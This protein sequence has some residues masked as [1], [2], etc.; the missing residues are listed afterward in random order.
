MPATVLDDASRLHLNE[1]SPVR[2]GLLAAI[3]PDASVTKHNAEHIRDR[4]PR[5]RPDIVLMN[6]P[7]AARPTIGKRRRH[8]DLKHLKSAYAALAPCGRLIAV[9][10]ANCIPEST[11]WRDAF[12]TGAAAPRILLAVRIP[13]ALY[14]R[15]GTGV[16]TRLVVLERAPAAS[17]DRYPEVDPFAL[18]EDAGDLVRRVAALPERLVLD[19]EPREL[20]IEPVGREGGAPAAYGS[21]TWTPWSP[22]SFRV[23]GAAEHPTPLVESAAM[24]DIAQPVPEYRPMLPPAL[25]AD[26]LLSD[27][28]FESVALAG[29]AHDR[30]LPTRYRIDAEFTRAVRR[31]TPTATPSIPT[32]RSTRR[33]PNPSGSAKAGCSATAPAAARGARP[34]P[35]SSTA[36]CAARSGRSGSASRRASSRTRAAT[37]AEIGRDERDIFALSDYRPAQPIVRRTGILFTTYATLR[38][39]ARGKAPARLDQ[40]IAWLAGGDDE[41]SRHAFDGVVVFDEAHAM[42]NAAGSATKQRGEA[43]PS[44]QGLA[45]LRLQ[46]ALPNA[47]VL[48]ASA[49]GATTVHG[50]AYAPRLGLWGGDATA[51]NDRM[52]FVSAM[53]RGGVAAMEIV[54]RD[55][56]SP[57]PLPGAGARLPR[58]R[59]RHRRARP[60]GTAARDLGPLRRRLPDHPP[61]HPRGAGSHRRHPGRR[62]PRP[63]REVRRDVRVRAGQTALLP[64]TCS[65]P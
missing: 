21:S 4:L 57:R 15:R 54:A 65:R 51:F 16:E 1:L 12:G 25:V 30:L 55:L 9:T 35:S 48:Y 62:H 60:D 10:G 2:H 46:H 6:P 39:P 44:Q 27:A 45:G 34:P 61:E 53:E 11:T 49:T 22:A 41:G 29:Q 5:V 40:I 43:K 8:I 3:Y 19:P 13:A 14:R 36:G 47:R 33:S 52:D 28:Q 42:A 20:H 26:G 18:A 37:G 64:A 7:F 23:P 17:A 31:W 63:R 50:L 32:S 58:R 56:K 24:A 38:S 59:N